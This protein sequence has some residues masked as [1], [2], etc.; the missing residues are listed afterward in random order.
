M[1][2][3]AHRSGTPTVSPFRTPSLAIPETE[4]GK[5]ISDFVEFCRVDERLQQSVIYSYRYIAIRFL[6]SCKGQVSKD[7]VRAYL[8]SYTGHSPK[9]YNNQIDGL[10]A[11]IGRFLSLP[12]LV[13]GFKDAHLE[14][15]YE[16]ELPSIEQLREGFQALMDDRERAIYLFYATS[17]LRK[18][19][20]LNLKKDDIDFEL[21]SVKSEHDT[22]TKKAEVSF[23][24]NECEEYLKRYLNSR[25][26]DNEKLFRIRTREFMRIWKKASN[27][28]TKI[29]P[30][31]LRK[32]HSTELGERGIP[33][34]Y[35]DVFQG[36]APRSVM[37]KFYTGKELFR[38]KRIYEKADLKIL[39]K[40][41][42]Q[43][44]RIDADQLLKR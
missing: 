26:D 33:D 31:I 17:G 27:A 14:N 23:Y 20:L 37:A 43:G 22:R 15:H 8:A 32:W 6:N 44:S 25:T 16:I 36:R 38:L 2:S 7:A 1:G 21:R 29:T 11:F 28:R 30:Q 13:Y 40:Q 4:I 34:R 24:N 12:E 3:K 5:T 19:E 42:E 9:T 10:R 41:N 18:S 35:V 39:D